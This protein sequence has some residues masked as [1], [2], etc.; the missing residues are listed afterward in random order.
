MSVESKEQL[1]CTVCSRRDKLSAEVHEIRTANCQFVTR[2]PVVAL[3]PRIF[4]WLHT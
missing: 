1:E 3:G 2:S 4:W